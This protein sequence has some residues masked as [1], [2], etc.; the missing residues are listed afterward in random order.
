MNHKQTAWYHRNYV[1]MTEQHLIK[2]FELVV[3][4][5]AISVHESA[6]AWTAW[7]CGDPTARMLGR[8]SLNPIR[9]ID[10]FGSIILPVVLVI[11][12]LP[13]FGWAKPTP[14]DPRNFKHQ[15]RDDILTAL[16]G[17][18]SNLLIATVAL[19]LLMIIQTLRTNASWLMPLALFLYLSIIVNVV[20]MVFNLIPLPPLDGSHVFR[21]LLSERGRHVYDQVGMVALV[22][23]L[24][25]FRDV[26]GRL[27]A[28]VIAMFEAFLR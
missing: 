2:A 11:M 4:L 23:L 9:H 5:F 20:L 19:V 24:L 8:I 21:H 25:V 28:P 1:R 15:V 16:A 26:I 14:V 18:V 27:S 12:G 13:P 3:L 7:R 17:P 6:H 22:A 10:L